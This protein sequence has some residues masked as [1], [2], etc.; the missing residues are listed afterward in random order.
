MWKAY[1]ELKSLGW[2]Q[3]DMPKFVCVQ[4]EGCQPIVDG[5]QLR[6][7]SVDRNVLPAVQTE[8]TASPTGMRVPN[9]PDLDL[10]LSILEQSRGTA[11]A[12]SKKQIA[13]A[14]QILGSQGIS[15]S[16]EGSAT[17][18]GLLALCNSGWLRPS[19]SVVLFNTSH[20]M[21]YATSRVLNSLPII[22]NYEEYL[23]LRNA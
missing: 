14:G 3:C 8:I 23:R 1:L 18:A 20:A 21:K 2:I 15:A 22:K 10:I 17:W 19:D 4:E 16:P 13:E 9:P 5:L 6:R 12:L 7:N 11:I